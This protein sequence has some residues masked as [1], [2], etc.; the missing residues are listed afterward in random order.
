MSDS[1]NSRRGTRIWRGDKATSK[2][3]K[4]E[5]RR[6]RSRVKQQDPENL[7]TR[8]RERDSYDVWNWT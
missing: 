3:R 7:P 2:E 6:H 1:K 8:E 4:I 5:N